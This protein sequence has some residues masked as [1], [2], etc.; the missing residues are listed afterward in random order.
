VVDAHCIRC[1]ASTNL[2]H[3]DRLSKK[4]IPHA[5]ADASR[6]YFDRNDELVFLLWDGVNWEWLFLKATDMRP[7]F[8]GIHKKGCPNR[9]RRNQRQTDTDG[10]PTCD[11][12]NMRVHEMCDA[13]DA[14][15]IRLPVARALAQP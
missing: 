4:V 2:K 12:C 3:V 13:I 6:R 10:K 5:G 7:R 11:Q 15:A 8:A 14:K 9:G 1:K